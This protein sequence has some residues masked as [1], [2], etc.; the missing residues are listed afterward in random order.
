M[1]N[2]ANVVKSRDGVVGNPGWQTPSAV[3]DK[4][5][6]EFGP[7]DMDPCSAHTAYTSTQVLFYYTPEG[8]FQMTPDGPLQFAEGEGMTRPWVGRVFCNP[9]YKRVE[10]WVKR[11]SEAAKAGALVVMLLIPSTDAQWFHK[12]CWD[13]ETHEPRI[14]VEVR[15]LQG[16]I[17]FVHPDPAKR[18]TDFKGFRPISGNMV[19][20]FHPWEASE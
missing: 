1:S 7:F 8:A 17:R 9:P 3:F 6:A 18:E 5:A 13:S 4:L 19:V 16:R 2:S 12:Y 11:G 10:E 14:G 20:V 15:F